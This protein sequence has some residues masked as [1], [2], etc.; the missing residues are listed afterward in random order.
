MV[1]DRTLGY[2]ARSLTSSLITSRTLTPSHNR[3]NPRFP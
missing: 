1:L 3:T 2:D